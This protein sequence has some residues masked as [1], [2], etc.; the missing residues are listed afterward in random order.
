[1]SAIGGTLANRAADRTRRC[2]SIAYH[3]AGEHIFTVADHPRRVRNGSGG[4]AEILQVFEA[5]NSGLITADA[6]VI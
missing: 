1:M 2:V 4:D 3:A 6:C 5:A